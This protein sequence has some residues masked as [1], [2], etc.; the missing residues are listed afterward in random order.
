[1]SLLSKI[2]GLGIK[3]TMEG[4]SSLAKG[5]RVAFTGD[6]PLSAE[7]KTALR[8]Q[9]LQLEGL[10]Q[11]AITKTDQLR[12]NIIIAEAQGDSWLQ[13]NWRPITMLVFVA[14]IVA[15]WLGWSAP[16]LTEQERLAVFEIIKIG[17]GGYVVGRSVEK[18]IKSW[19]G[20]S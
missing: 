9:V 15:H 18:G 11:D 13:R 16:G 5:L 10:V 2:A 8:G 1:M 3:D 20:E 4:V 17:L 19:K 12:G 6:D 14:L 7:Q